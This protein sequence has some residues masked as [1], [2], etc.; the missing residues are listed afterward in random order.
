M[1]PQ[2]G[3]GLVAVRVR[4]RVLALSAIGILLWLRWSGSG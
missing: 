4:A 3:G 2:G 1:L